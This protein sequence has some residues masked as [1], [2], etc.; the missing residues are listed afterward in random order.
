MPKAI[1]LLNNQKFATTPLFS[2]RGGSYTRGGFM[3]E[4]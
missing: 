2:N 4:K 1:K 3:A